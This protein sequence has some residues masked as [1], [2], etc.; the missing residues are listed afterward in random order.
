MKTWE[1]I[2]F[3]CLGLFMLWGCGIHA[4]YPE[5][6]DLKATHL[7]PKEN[8]SDIAVLP[9]M[10][11][12]GAGKVGNT[13]EDLREAFY[14]ELINRRYSPLD[15]RYVDKVRKEKGLVSVMDVNSLAGAFGEDALLFITVT[16]WDERHFYVE[17]RIVCAL[18]IQLVSSKSKAEI[19]GGT[20]DVS[21]KLPG[22]GMI[23]TGEEEFYRR[24]AAF[25]AAKRA[26]ST[27]PLR[28]PVSQ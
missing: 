12:E 25:L 22:H 17:R 24:K 2:G 3:V 4:K 10:V 5:K 16:F 9:V 26:L 19:W 18:K 28:R 23:E 8:P 1:K 15:L 7:L 6:I 20:M 27:L 11:A 13:A 14:K 21:L